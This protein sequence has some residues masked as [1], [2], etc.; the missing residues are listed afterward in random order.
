MQVAST[1]TFDTGTVVFDVSGIPDGT[2]TLTK[3]VDSARLPAG[4]YYAR[5]I[6]I[7]ANEPERFFQVSGNKLY[8]GN[9][10]YYGA[11]TFTV[12]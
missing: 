7:P 4:K 2:G 12:N 8:V 6:A 1:P 3:S 10:T 5:L 9:N 11:I